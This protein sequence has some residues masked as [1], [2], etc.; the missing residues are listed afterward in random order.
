MKKL[1]AYWR[2]ETRRP[3]SNY[4]LKLDWDTCSTD[5][6][7]WLLLT[8]WIAHYGGFY[9]KSENRIRK[10]NGH[11]VQN[12]SN[13]I[14]NSYLK[15]DSQSMSSK[16]DFKTLFLRWDWYYVEFFVITEQTCQGLQTLSKFGTGSCCHQQQFYNMWYHEG[17]LLQLIKLT[18]L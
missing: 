4:L 1:L 5:V 12:A 8:A 9:H 18:L 2:T 16:Q 10:V 13:A 14:Q 7:W 11:Q 6:I 15:W 17:R 3:N